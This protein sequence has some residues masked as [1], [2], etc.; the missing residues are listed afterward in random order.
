MT[1]VAHDPVWMQPSHCIQDGTNWRWCMFTGAEQ[2]A[3]R[4]EQLRVAAIEDRI[5]KGYMFAKVAD[6]SLAQSSTAM[7]Y[8][9]QQ[10]SVVREARKAMQKL[11]AAV[12]QQ[13]QSTQAGL[14]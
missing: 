14:Q 10:L 2:F 5:A 9:A 7:Q 3:S 12:V 1:S 11:Q 13:Q 4:L 6:D 8:M